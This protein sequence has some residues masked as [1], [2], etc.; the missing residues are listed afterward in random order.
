MTQNA[1]WLARYHAAK[2]GRPPVPQAPAYPPGYAPPQPPPQPYAPPP[3]AAY[4]VPGYPPPQQPP[5][6][7]QQGPQPMPGAPPHAPFGYDPSTGVPLAPYGRDQFG[8]V[9]TQ[10]PVYYPPQPPPGYPPQQQQPYQQPQ[11]PP[12]YGQPYGMPQ[13]QQW[14]PPVEYDQQGNAVVH[15]MDAAAAFKGGKGLQAA[16]PCPECGGVM[17]QPTASGEGRKLNVKTG[18]FAYAAGHCTNCG[19][20]GIASPGAAT[21]AIAGGVSGVGIQ[22]AGPARPAPGAGSV[23]QTANQHGLPNLFA[24][25]I[26]PQ[27]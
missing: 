21:M 20:N 6:P 2:T 10:P 24:P 9:I 7:Y 8:A 23:M 13:Q 18:E 17:F 3:P 25:K 22:M 12:Q 26:A 5:Q 1:D 27:R 14:A 4:N 16:E 15:A 19:Y 11:Q